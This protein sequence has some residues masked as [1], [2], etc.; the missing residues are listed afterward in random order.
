MPDQTAG[1]QH[2]PRPAWHRLADRI[3]D[4]SVELRSGQKLLVT[5]TSPAVYPLAQ[6]LAEGA[7]RRGAH[8]HALLHT[9]DVDEAIR[10]FGNDEQARQRLE[11]ELCAMSWADAHVA[12]RALAPPTGEAGDEGFGRRA[13][14]LRAAH[15][16]VSAA[17]WA[18]TRWCIVRVPTAEYADYL[19]LP[20]ETLEAEFLRGSIDDDGWSSWLGLAAA[21]DGAREVRIVGDDTDL[22]FSVEGR[23]W[24]LFDGRMNLPDGEV[25]TAPV[26]TTVEGHITFTDPLVFGGQRID[27]LRLDF[28]GGRVTSVEAGPATG[29]VETIVATDDGAS[30]VGEYGIGVNRHIESW[31][32]DLFFDEKIV[33]TT[34]IALGR[35]YPECGGINQSAIHWDIVKD[36]RPGPSRAGG[37]VYVDGEVVLDGAQLRIPGGRRGRT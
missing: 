27:R 7:V 14:L 29:F 15:G 5:L 19:G 20:V 24:K 30:R 28:R 31:T 3:L 26:E 2:G 36:L 37:R 34:H 23:T 21:L 11:V 25:A 12:L 10:R 17:R 13:A 8:H 4:E 33:G 18:E 16:E 9:E 6:A 1:D 32:Q 35:A 22:A